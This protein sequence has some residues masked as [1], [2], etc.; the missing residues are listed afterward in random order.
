MLGVEADDVGRVEAVGGPLLERMVLPVGDPVVRDGPD[1]KTCALD[2]G[3]EPARRLALTELGLE[4]AE[5]VPGM[6]RP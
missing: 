1:R 5:A 3:D 4:E 6:L 2:C